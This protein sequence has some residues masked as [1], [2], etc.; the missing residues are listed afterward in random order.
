MSVNATGFSAQIIRSTIRTDTG[1]VPVVVKHDTADLISRELT[2]YERFSEP[3][4][5]W[6]PELR[7]SGVDDDLGIGVLILE[8]VTPAA[9]LDVLS[10]CDDTQAGAIVTAL[11]HLH[12]ADWTDD[13]RRFEPDLPRWRRRPMEP[14]RWADRIAVA[15]DR[16]P[17]TFTS[18]VVDRLAD[19]PARVAPAVARLDRAPRTWIH[20]DVHLDNVMWRQDRGLVLLD[21][22]TSSVGP[23]VVD[24]AGCLVGGLVDG[25]DDERTGRMIA[26]YRA[27]LRD[28]GIAVDAT[29]LTE[30]I[31]VAILPMTQGLVGWAGSPNLSPG[32]RRW[33]VCE[34]QVRLACA[35][36]PG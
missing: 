16:F 8:D 27:T 26:S 18:D 33:A 28:H 17:D 10:G 23:A 12:A 2:F 30:L 11:A 25:P 3:V 15:R 19:L 7:G 22:A 36:L 14:E 29:K 5:A 24:L 1:T 32:D 13:D 6:I 4:R 20:G 35:W 9:Q 31:T 34:K 21:W